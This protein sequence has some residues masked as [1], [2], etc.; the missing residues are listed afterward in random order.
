MY[1]SEVGGGVEEGRR[2]VGRV[3]GTVSGFCF[4]LTKKQISL[5]FCASYK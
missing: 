2:G 1:I 3:N 5:F 4:A